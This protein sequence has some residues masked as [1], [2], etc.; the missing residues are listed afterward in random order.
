MGGRDCD[1]AIVGSGP[2]GLACAAYLGG[3]RG[4]D[5]R[6][7]GDPMSFWRER[8]PAGMLLRSP[9]VASHIA[10]PARALTLDAYQED[11]GARFGQPVPLERFVEYGCWFERRAGIE[12][13]R[14]PVTRVE[15]ENGGFRL[16]LEDGASIAAS[17]VVVA[18]GIAPFA[19]VPEQFR[20]LPGSAVSHSSAHRD[21][22]AFAGQRVL[23]VGGGQS[24]LESAALLHEA[25][26]AVEVL[27][28]HSRI[29][30]LRR[31]GWL[32][33]LGPITRLL[34]APAEVG[35][36]GISQVVSR[37][38]L[39]RRLSREV[40]DRWAVRSLRPAG[41]AWLVP[42]LAAVPIVTS[43]WITSARLAGDEVEARLADG[44]V[45][46]VDHILLATGYKVDVGGYGF[47]PP[48]LLERIDRVDGFPRL[49]SSFE[50]SVPGLHFVGAVAAWSFG[51][52]MRF[53]AGTEYAG[54]A[55][56]AALLGRRR[57]RA[58]RAAP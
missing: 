37:P 33:K 7:L 55:V 15:Q 39:Y 24:A 18:A 19:V 52:L 43:S 25:G 22:A 27:V 44:T 54:S 36:A 4:L 20:D 50:S 10:D 23:V 21:L 1:V 8:M 17:R 2:Y 53:V 32:H 16:A 34:F 40:Q 30:F 5:V 26:A 29:F 28:R 58:M 6:V 46:R 38:T 12:S 3:D 14:R 47:L 48:A 45:R 11:S 57:R 13:D 35:P 49:T 41:A 9:Y 31:V 51:P 42:R 56:A